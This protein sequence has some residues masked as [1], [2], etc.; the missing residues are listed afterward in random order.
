MHCHGDR[1]INGCFQSPARG[2]HCVANNFFILVL[3]SHVR[4]NFVSFAL[5]TSTYVV[6]ERLRGLSARTLE[7]EF[8]FR[9]V[10][11]SRRG[12]ISLTARRRS[13]EHGAHQLRIIQPMLGI[14][15]FC[16]V[17]PSSF[18]LFI[19]ELSVTKTTCT[20]LHF[21]L[22]NSLYE[23]IITPSESYRH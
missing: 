19:T 23:E 16:S 3:C 6:S 1:P 2:L 12:S 9:I 7:T 18:S 8:I 10:S 11:R 22:Y 15:F 5:S 20:Q 13:K 4:R 21:C 14:V 17:R